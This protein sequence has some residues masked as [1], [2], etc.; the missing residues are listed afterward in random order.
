MSRA[1]ALLLAGAALLAAA[2]AAQAGL[3]STAGGDPGRSGFQ[4]RAAGSA[5]YELLWNTNGLADRDVVTGVVVTGSGTT[6]ER[7]RA[8]Y[9]TKDGRL[10]LRDLFTGEAVGDPGGLALGDYGDPKALTGDGG[11]L[12]PVDSSQ[13]ESLGQLFVVLNDRPPK[14]LKGADGEPVT[15]WVVIAQVDEQTGKLVQRRRVPG[16]EELVVSSTPLLGE[17]NTAGDRSI[18]F[19][20]SDGK[21][22]DLVVRV[23]VKR[24][25]SVTA[26][27]DV[28]D[29][30]TSS[31]TEL[32]PTAAPTLLVADDQTGTRN[33]HPTAFATVASGAP[34]AP[35]T[36]LQVDA[37]GTSG[38]ASQR[39]DRT[40]T[41]KQ[42][43]YVASVAVPVTPSGF[44]PGTGTSGAGR[45]GAVFATTYDPR[46]DRT[47]AHR[48]V[49]TPDGTGLVEAAASAPIA[50]RPAPQLTTTQ[51][52]QAP[53]DDAGTLVVTTSK[54][55]VALDGGD[56]SRRWAQEDLRPEDTGFGRTSASVMNGVVFVARDN[57]ERLALALADGS[58]LPREAFDTTTGAQATIRS[59]GAPAVTS[60]GV[61]VF[62]SDK[63][64][65]AFRNRCGN[66][67]G[68]TTKND[69][70]AG[71]L[72]G[73][74]VQAYQGDDTVDGKAGDDCLA[75]G[76]GDDVLGGGP[77]LDALFG[78]PGADRLLGGSEADLLD[79]DVGPDRLAGDDGDD[80]L[81]G[82]ADADVL[83]GGDGADVLAGDDGADRL[84][85]GSKDDRLD[86]GP[87]ND[88]VSGGAGADRLRGG[89]GRD[90]LLGGNGAD[91]LLAR[92]GDQ[93]TVRCGAGR[94]TAVVDRFDRVAGCETVRG[95]RAR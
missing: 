65:V 14:D 78:G 3:W 64:V 16:T 8:V 32:W 59:V 62:A 15:D 70:I 46:A 7:P 77:G 24:A 37:L 85:G 72:A 73:D 75:G 94:D 48:L 35:L 11:A 29:A 83:K 20:A 13:E 84:Y 86:G 92:D 95:R 6:G 71:T 69:A 44:A 18:V 38:P 60:A 30:E 12:T 49:L 76:A 40:A 93:D 47:V 63:G 66:R 2:P 82:G 34:D 10:H 27:L 50:G 43:V 52:G 39:L 9:G 81:R 51:D 74:D 31:V 45:A 91:T 28:A 41:D 58:A 23:P 55:L 25:Q 67:L 26:S 89:R 17:P 22:K 57:G 4:P 68:G 80:Q 53:G 5:P 87:G 90:V 56:L 88:R 54:A 1:R 21:E 33:S 61:V 42:P 19:T 79:G 36:S